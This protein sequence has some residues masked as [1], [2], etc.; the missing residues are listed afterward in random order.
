MWEEERQYF[1]VFVKKSDH[2]EIDTKE[3]YWAYR[4]SEYGVWIII[5]NYPA[6]FFFDN[7]EIFIF[8]SIGKR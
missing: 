3:I 6:G 7:S 1:Q 4:N 2:I 8:R 5:E